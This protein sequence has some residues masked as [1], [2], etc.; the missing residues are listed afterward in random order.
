MLLGITERL[1]LPASEGALVEAVHQK[2]LTQLLRQAWPVFTGAEAMPN[3]QN[4]LHVWKP[5]GTPCG[6]LCADCQSRLWREN[7]PLMQILQ[8]TVQ[9]CSLQCAAF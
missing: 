4:C 9:R 8:A 1:I 7:R 3:M 2:G 5:T 6:W